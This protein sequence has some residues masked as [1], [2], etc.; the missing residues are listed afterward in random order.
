V[1]ATLTRSDGA[2]GW[3]AQPDGRCCRRMG[4]PPRVVTLCTSS[5]GQARRDGTH[6]P[7]LDATGCCI[8]QVSYPDRGG[9]TGT[10][11]PCRAAELT[12]LE[13]QVLKPEHAAL[14]ARTQR[15]SRMGH[16]PPAALPRARRARGSSAS[17]HPNEP[18]R[19]AATTCTREAVV[20][21]PEGAWL[22]PC[23]CSE[24]VLRRR[25]YVHGCG[26]N[27]PSPGPGTRFIYKREEA[28]GAYRGG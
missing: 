23:G 28:L 20:L 5:P 21:D 18:V 22:E 3:V 26:S 6:P 24:R 12:P 16:A 7:A 8:S 14:L 2:A 19:Y 13:F 11:V 27:R 1:R 15:A 17:A 10:T 4:T 25:L 9:W